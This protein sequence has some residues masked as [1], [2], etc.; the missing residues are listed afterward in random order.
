MKTIADVFDATQDIASARSVYI[1]LSEI[2]SDEGS[3]IFTRPIK[4]IADRAAVSYRTT[5]SILTRFEALKLIAVERHVVEGTKERAPSTFTMLG[6]GCRTLGNGCCRLSLPRI[7]KE[8]DKKNER[9]EI[10]NTHSEVLC[11]DGLKPGEA[12]I[13]KRYNETFVPLGWLPLDKITPAVQN[14]LQNCTPD[15]FDNLV[16]IAADRANWPRK[17]TFTTLLWN[18]RTAAERLRRLPLNVLRQRR[19]KAQD[20]RNRLFDRKDPNANRERREQLKREI[21]E[22]E[23]ITKTRMPS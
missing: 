2:A 23:E 14:V 8:T 6:N 21:D 5:A 15:I 19:Q 13:I 17:R 18:T 9:K 3:E 10:K 16:P 11:L 7:E 22:I 1:A 4:Q 12:E 20:E